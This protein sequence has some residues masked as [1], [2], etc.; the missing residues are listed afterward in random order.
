MEQFKLRT[1]SPTDEFVLLNEKLA[2]IRKMIPFKKEYFMIEDIK[3]SLNELWWELKSVENSRTT[4][5]IFSLEEDL[6][7]KVKK[8][9]SPIKLYIGKELFI[10]GID[11]T[12]EKEELSEWLLFQE[13]MVCLSSVLPPFIR[14]QRVLPR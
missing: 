9:V 8:L 10:S 12:N 11:N 3:K 2:R 1:K 14:F 4:R 5:E 7:K 13:Y 6:Y